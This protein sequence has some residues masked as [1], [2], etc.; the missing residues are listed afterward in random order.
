MNNSEI[1]K[2]IISNINT[3]YEN[4]SI[5][6]AFFVMEPHIF[7]EINNEL[8]NNQYP[9]CTL[10]DSERFINHRARI[11]SINNIDIRKVYDN[12][13][14]MNSLKDVNL[15]IFIETPQ[16]YDKYFYKNFFDIT[17]FH[18]NKINVFEL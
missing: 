6:K 18:N 17:N 11:I 14:L 3:I 1:I 2:T 8:I 4:I 9:I 15:I 13:E 12:T 7:K 5:T 16:I 10:N